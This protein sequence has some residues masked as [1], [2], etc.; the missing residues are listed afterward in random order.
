MQKVYS[1][2]FMGTTS[3]ESLNVIEYHD[4]TN[5]R[6]MQTMPAMIIAAAFFFNLGLIFC[7][8]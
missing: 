6:T 3:L 4:D 8:H 7:I 1:E 5:R 2:K